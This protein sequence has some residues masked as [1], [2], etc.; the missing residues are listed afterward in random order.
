MKAIIGKFSTVLTML[1]ILSIWLLLF[2]S[3]IS[4]DKLELVDFSV[5]EEI[6]YCQIRSKLSNDFDL[7]LPEANYYISFNGE[8]CEPYLEILDFEVLVF[9]TNQDCKVQSKFIKDPNVT[10]MFVTNDPEALSKLN[11]DL[12]D[13]FDCTFPEQPYFFVA[14]SNVSTL[15]VYEVQVYCQ[16]IEIVAVFINTVNIWLLDQLTFQSVEERRA[17]FRGA[18]VHV[19]YDSY[20]DHNFQGYSGHLGSLIAQKFNI[21]LDKAIIKRFG[22]ILQNGSYTGT[23]G[24][25]IQNKIDIGNF[26]PLNH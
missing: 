5:L 10:Y 2:Q 17:N 13:A 24:A 16:H 26:T 23:V 15:I 4:Y 3:V 22:T 7:Q 18:T 21:T 11:P 20:T 12:F 6:N 1:A 19:H 25:L 8:S 14:F 9:N